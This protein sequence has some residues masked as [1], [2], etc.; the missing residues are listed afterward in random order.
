MTTTP[1]QAP[2]AIFDALSIA[3]ARTLMR[4]ITKAVADTS[5]VCTILYRAEAWR[6]PDLD[7]RYHDM[8][9]DLCEL[10]SDVFDALMA[11]YELADAAERAYVAGNVTP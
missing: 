2:A 11:K 9:K 3:Q 1:G 6:Y 5:A 7:V 10:H 8:H 4:R